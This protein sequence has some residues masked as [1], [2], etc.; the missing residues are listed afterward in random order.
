M[1]IGIKDLIIEIDKM[2]KDIAYS[3]TSI[4]FLKENNKDFLDRLEKRME[5]LELKNED[6][7]RRLA[8]LEG[9]VDGVLKVSSHSA[10]ISLLEKKLENEDNLKDIDIKNLLKK[11]DINNS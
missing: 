2:R 6:L 9:V 8:S 4:D 10:I 3:K 1:G 7:I 11:Q 5:K